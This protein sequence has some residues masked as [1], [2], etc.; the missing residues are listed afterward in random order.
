MHKHTMHKH[1]WNSP[2]RAAAVAALVW[3]RRAP[4]SRC[5]GG[6]TPVLPI[7][8]DASTRF[9]SDRR[10]APPARR[11]VVVPSRRE[12]C[13]RAG[14]GDSGGRLAAASQRAA[15]HVSR[16]PEVLERPPRHSRPGS[17]RIFSH[18]EGVRRGR[19]LASAPSRRAS[20]QCPPPA[21]GDSETRSRTPEVLGRGTSAARSGPAFS[22]APPPFSLATRAS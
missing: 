6:R 1:I 4:A 5:R 20:I 8:A 18:G 11:A 12:R 9:G 13:G 3:N 7:Q 19:W 22:S 21:D 2:V 16:A 15:T 14:R 17:R 10:G